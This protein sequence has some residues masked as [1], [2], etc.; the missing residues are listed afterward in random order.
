MLVIVEP[1]TPPGSA[2]VRAARS[3]VLQFEARKVRAAAKRG[4]EAAGA[5]EAGA[6]SAAADGAAS[7]AELQPEIVGAHVVAPCAHDKRCPMDGTDRWCHFSQRL[8]RP[9]TQRA[10][11]GGS[12]AR[13]YQVRMLLCAWRFELQLTRSRCRMSASRMW[14]CAVAP[15]RAWLRRWMRR[16]LLLRRRL[17]WQS[18]RTMMPLT[19]RLAARLR[20]R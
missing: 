4:V 18:C 17:T 7:A 15:V 19:R 14:C 11:K 5:V 3:T 20:S 9:D 13:T 6:R 16:P 12:S 8:Q 2:V 1:G 10:V